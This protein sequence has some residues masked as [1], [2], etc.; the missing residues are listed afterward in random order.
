MTTDDGD[1]PDTDYCADEIPGFEK[2]EKS[3]LPP[4]RKQSTS[5]LNR[6]V[7]VAQA[8]ESEVSSRR[9]EEVSG[10]R[11]IYTIR[12]ANLILLSLVNALILTGVGQYHSRQGK[13]SLLIT[14]NK[15]YYDRSSDL[16][17]TFS[18][19][20][21]LGQYISIS[22]SIL[23]WSSTFIIQCLQC[24]K[25]RHTR[26]M[27]LIYAFGSVPLSLF[28]F[29]I[30]MH[31]SACPWIDEFFSNDTNRIRYMSGDKFYET[32]CGVNGWALAGIFS[33]LSCG[34]YVSEGLI[35]TFFRNEDSHGSNE[36]SGEA[37]L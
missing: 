6:L 22:I 36:K 20:K 34:L 28:V 1:D 21:L 31:Y 27:C 16:P 19:M 3:I 12:M 4:I 37:I 26:I 11:I 13:Q 15:W 9:Q 30:E 14:M 23:L 25:I 24:C 7:L 32:Q 5:T 18:E 33:L 17:L 10:T 29:G 2:N 35:T 8:L